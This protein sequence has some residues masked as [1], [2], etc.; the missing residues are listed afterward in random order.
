[1]DPAAGR[2][3]AGRSACPGDEG[4]GLTMDALTGAWQWLTTAANWAGGK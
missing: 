4:G 2:G 3:P 1:M